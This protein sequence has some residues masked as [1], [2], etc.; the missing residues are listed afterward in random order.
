MAFGFG[1]SRIIAAIA[2]AWVT[3]FVLV[4]VWMPSAWS[5]LIL[6]IVAFLGALWLWFRMNYKL[7]AAYAIGSMITLLIA[8]VFRF[9]LF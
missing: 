4:A 1:E 3:A 9:G 5:L 7:L 8:A 2:G 6:G